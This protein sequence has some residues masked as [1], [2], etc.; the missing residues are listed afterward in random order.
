MGWVFEVVF[1]DPVEVHD[2]RGINQYMVSD[3]WSDVLGKAGGVRGGSG[4][5]RRC[6]LLGHAN[7]SLSRRCWWVREI[8]G[9]LFAFPLLMQCGS[10]ASHRT[11][12]AVSLVR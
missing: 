3:W 8:L 9:S 1:V 12:C 5:K 7:N 6:C 11:V 2:K 10:V 4:V